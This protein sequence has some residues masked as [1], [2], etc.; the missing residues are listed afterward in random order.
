MILLRLTQLFD[1]GF[2][3]LYKNDNLKAVYRKDY[4]LLPT[5][6][7]KLLAKKIIKGFMNV[8]P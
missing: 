2:L 6:Y 1:I 7:H 4:L 8:Y 5:R 3:N